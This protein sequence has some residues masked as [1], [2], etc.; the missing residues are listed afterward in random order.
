MAD[1]TDDILEALEKDIKKVYSK[2]YAEIKEQLYKVQGMLA[3]IPDADPKKRYLLLKRDKLQ[4]I[5]RQIIDIEANANNV[6]RKM[7]ENRMHEV[8]KYNYNT[9]AEQLGFSILDNFAVKKIL[10]KEENP[11]VLVKKLT[12]R[13]EATAR[14]RG[15]F[16]TSLLQ[17]EGINKMARRFK[18]VTEKSLKDAVR[19]ARTETTRVQNSAK[20]DVGEHGK[21][22]GYR[23]RKRWVATMDHRTRDEHLAMDGVEVDTDLP[24][25]MPDGTK[26]MFPGDPNGG[27]HQVVNCRCTMVEFIMRDRDGNLITKE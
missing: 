10:T 18:N 8:Y 21:E 3:S 6:A 4:A 22:L 19:I 5:E 2:A 12:N 15:E 16:V 1:R 27:A 9:S 26:M 25:V 14:L 11:F 7:V 17:G 23:M 24:F 13:A 20:M